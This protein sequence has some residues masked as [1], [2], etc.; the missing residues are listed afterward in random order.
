M[1]TGG[2]Q[3]LASSH[4]LSLATVSGAGALV[5][6]AALT[7]PGGT[8]SAA[9]D[10]VGRGTAVAAD[11]QKWTRTGGTPGRTVKS[12]AAGAILGLLAGSVLA[13]AVALAVVEH[14][15]QCCL[16]KPEKVTVQS[17]RSTWPQLMVRS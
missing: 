14:R 10:G 13:G 4:T 11:M 8:S 2:V 7:S 16:A 9:K 1:D 17:S 6:L 3:L 5:L 12:E 15:R